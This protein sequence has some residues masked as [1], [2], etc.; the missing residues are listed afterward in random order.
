MGIF[1]SYLQQIDKSSGSVI[2]LREVSGTSGW[3]TMPLSTQYVHEVEANYGN[4]ASDGQWTAHAEIRD[5][6][7]RWDVA[8]EDLKCDMVDLVTVSD[9]FGKKLGDPG[10]TWNYWMW[11]SNAWKGDVNV[12]LM[13]DMADITY[14]VDNFGRYY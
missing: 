11:Q 9:I 1:D 12:D 3:E 2:N 14:I 8:D 6:G 10:V 13:I 7:I 5:I 4:Y